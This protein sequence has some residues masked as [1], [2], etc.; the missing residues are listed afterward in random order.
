M[1]TD[2][3]VEE[4]RGRLRG[5]EGIVMRTSV[6]VDRKISGRRERKTMQSTKKEY[7]CL[8]CKLFIF[9]KGTLDLKV[10]YMSSFSV[11]VNLLDFFFAGV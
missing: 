9:K 10:R 6:C 3:L 11:Q 5:G 8:Y 2:K 7:I 4:E 1:L